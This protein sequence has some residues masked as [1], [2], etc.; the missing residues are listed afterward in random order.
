MLGKAAIALTIAAAQPAL[1]QTVS[2]YSKRAQDTRT[3]ELVEAP[4][5]VPGRVFSV[6]NAPSVGRDWDL[7]T[8]THNAIPDAYP[9]P[10]P[11]PAAYGAG[12]FDA[13]TIA[14]RVGQ[15]RIGISPW[16]R[17][18]SDT[19][20]GVR[21]KIER[22]RQLWLRQHGYTGGVRT[23]RNHTPEHNADAQA[24]A[25]GNPDWREG[26]WHKIEIRVPKRPDLL[27]D[28]AQPAPSARVMTGAA[29]ARVAPRNDDR[30]A[31]NNR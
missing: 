12:E 22:E 31:S 13:R 16:V 10:S 25:E 6:H 18:N 26:K 19:S 4:A 17:V 21:A 30:L 11:G 7:R 14:V 8:Y 24:E 29:T 5:M 23:F 20:N 3:I 9:W 1:A 27:V 2:I 15:T 28:S